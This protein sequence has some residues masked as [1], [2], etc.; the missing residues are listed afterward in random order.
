MAVHSLTPRHHN[1]KKK[2]KKKSPIIFHLAGDGEKNAKP[3]FKDVDMW[4][5]YIYIFLYTPQHRE[6]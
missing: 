1:G 4:N 3:S 6:L 5:E 2:K